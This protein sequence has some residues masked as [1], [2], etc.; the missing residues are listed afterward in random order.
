M[1]RALTG[2]TCVTE[3][4]P[5]GFNRA[6]RSADARRAMVIVGVAG[7]SLMAGIPCFAAA[8]DSAPSASIDEIV[9]TADKMSSTTV[10]QAPMAIQA[11]SGDAL[12]KQGVAGFMDL[13]G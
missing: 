12:Q 6:A 9:V 3:R 5:W 1:K 7:A 11:I 13:A 10:L 4:T 8:A 2:M